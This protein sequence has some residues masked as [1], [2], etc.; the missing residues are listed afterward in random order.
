MGCDY[1]GNWSQPEKIK[2]PSDIFDLCADMSF[3]GQEIVKVISLDSKSN[4][5]S[6][7][8]IT[9]GTVNA[10]LIHPREVFKSAI[11]NSAV[12][13]VLVHNHP[14]GDPAPSHADREITKRLRECSKI[15]GIDIIDHI[16]MG[17]GRFFSFTLDKE[18]QGGES[19][20]GRQGSRTRKVAETENGN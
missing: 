1:T 18:L 4:V 13:F 20:H 3:L 9:R 17:K 6:V 7:E 10:S 5:I 11:S 16:I 12:S 14:S 19:D 8:T 2:T 15:V